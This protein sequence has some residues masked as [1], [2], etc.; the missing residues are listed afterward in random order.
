MCIGN[1]KNYSIYNYA[2]LPALYC[3]KHKLEN[4][5][6]TRIQCTMCNRRASFNNLCGEHKKRK[7][8]D[9][10]SEWDNFVFNTDLF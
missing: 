7:Y 6:D 5:V 8:H 2:G 10:V 3:G 1:C 9:M 4:M